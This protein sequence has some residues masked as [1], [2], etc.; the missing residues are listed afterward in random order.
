MDTEDMANFTTPAKYKF[1][2]VNAEEFE[3]ASEQTLVTV[4]QDESGSVYGFKDEME[5]CLKTI[6]GACQKDPRSENQMLRF[7]TFN[8][9]VSEVFGFRFLSSID[10]DEF[11]DSLAP[12]GGTALYDSAHTAIQATQT[13]GEDLVDNGINV[14][15]IVFVITDGDNNSSTFGPKQIKE[16]LEDV[17]KSEKI[18][19]ILV[20]LVGITGGSSSLQSYLDNFKDEAGLDAFIDIGDATPGALAKLA[21][22]V[23]QS[24]SSQS[25]S[26]NSGGPSK[27]LTF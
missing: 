9:R 19:S 1:S 10:P 18:E 7:V 14:N 17:R 26:L 11:D 15:A 25:Q 16:L 6:L 12:G 22:F 8:E 27:L 23:S 3:G 2:G 20:V 4:I 21:K 24:V 5:K 13:Y